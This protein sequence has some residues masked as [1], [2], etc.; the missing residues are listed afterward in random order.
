VEGQLAGDQITRA[1]TEGQRLGI[2]LAEGGVMA[3]EGLRACVGLVHHAATEIDAIDPMGLLGEG[4]C[5]KSCPAG[6]ISDTLP[7]RG[8]RH[9]HDQLQQPLIGHGATL[10]IVG[11]LPVKLGAHLRLHGC[12]WLISHGHVLQDAEKRQPET[13][14]WLL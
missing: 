9:P 7:R 4:A 3:A 13:L 14:T 5:E 11:H 8:T 2:R 12:R 6:H 10:P 1:V